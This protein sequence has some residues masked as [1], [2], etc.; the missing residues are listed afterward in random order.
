LHSFSQLSKPKGNE[1]KGKGGRGAT[2][3]MAGVT[4][5]SVSKGFEAANFI[6][7]EVLLR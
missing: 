1:V 5:F 4:G 7:E 2:I 3:F 6:N